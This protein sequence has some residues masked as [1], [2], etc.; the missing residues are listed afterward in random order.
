MM[1]L[2]GAPCLL[3]SGDLCERAPMDHRTEGSTPSQSIAFVNSPQT[4]S[5]TAMPRPR[6]SLR[7]PCHLEVRKTSLRA[8]SPLNTMGSSRRRPSV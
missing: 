1:K 2:L 5:G 8:S 4:L 7:R 6:P 3:M